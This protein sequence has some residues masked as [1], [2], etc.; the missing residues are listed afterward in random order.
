MEIGACTARGQMA[1]NEY[2]GAQ[3]R[4]I[5]TLGLLQ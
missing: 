5:A 2:L 4:K 3:H 1:F